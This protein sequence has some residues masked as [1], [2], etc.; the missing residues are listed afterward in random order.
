MTIKTDDYIYTLEDMILL[1]S[2]ENISFFPLTRDFIIKTFFNNNPL[3]YKE[4]LIL[5]IKDIINL[6]S[7]N[8]NITFN[9]VELGKT[10][11]KEYNKILDNYITLN[12]NIHIDFECNSSSFKHVK[13]RNILYKNKLSTKVLETGDNINKLK[14]IYIIQLNI[15]A[16]K[17]DLSYGEDEIIL[18][19]KKTNKI[20]SKL[21]YIVIKNIAY[22]RNLFYNKHVLLPKDKMWLVVLSSTN[23]QELFNT[24]KYV[25]ND[26]DR[27]KLI[28]DVIR[29][30][31]D[32]FSLEMWKQQY[33]DKLNEI[34]RM[35][36]YND[37]LEHGIELESINT[38][39]SMLKKNYS[40]E[41]ISDVTGKTKEEIEEIKKS[42]N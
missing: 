1:D 16:S 2:D 5:Q 20:F 42:I 38:V 37:G 12:D 41:L 35:S 10:N 31:S 33:A 3:I 15:N 21:E 7:N 11:Y 22:Y 27:N 36:V 19:G 26:T 32:G 23:Y 39:K 17:E 6:D 24:L 28:K 14:N 29:M 13:E 8:T 4:F 25:V 40:L 34:V 18:F 9:N 30:F